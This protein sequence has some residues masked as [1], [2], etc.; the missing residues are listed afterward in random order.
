MH[1]HL[2][3]NMYANRAK[4]RLRDGDGLVLFTQVLLNVSWGL[5]SEVS[6]S[7]YSFLLCPNPWQ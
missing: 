3:I 6:S 1:M 7:F 2:T 4:V 5:Y